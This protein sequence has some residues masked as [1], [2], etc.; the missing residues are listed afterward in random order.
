VTE[1]LY[2]LWLAMPAGARPPDHY[3]LLGVATFCD[4][5]PAIEAATRKQLR[6]LDKYA[7]HPD[8]AK[9]AACAAMMNEVARARVCLTHAQRK[10]A[11][12]ESLGRVHA[13]PQ[14][15]SPAAGDGGNLPVLE[16]ALPPQV[17]PATPAGA[18]VR[19]E[20]RQEVR[21]HLHQWILNGH[22][23]RLLLATAES[24]GLAERTAR[25]IIRRVDAEAD[26]AAQ[27]ASRRWSY[28]L[29][30]GAAA[31]L[32]IVLAVIFPPAWLGSLGDLF[33][34][35]SQ[36]PQAGAGG[37]GERKASDNAP[38]AAAMQTRL[39][40]ALARRAYAEVPAMVAQLR[41]VGGAVEAEDLVA[42]HAAK[43]RSD[44]TGLLTAGQ[45]SDAAKTSRD[46]ALLSPGD[47]GAAGQIGKKTAALVLA[48]LS[49]HDAS[50]ARRDVEAAL[51]LS[52]TDGGALSAAR[53]IARK[54]AGPAAAG[55]A[56]REVAT[57][58]PAGEHPSSGPTA[59]AK[60]PTSSPGEPGTQAAVQNRWLLEA[61]R[62][63]ASWPADPAAMS[64]AQRAEVR[65]AWADVLRALS[66]QPAD[67]GALEL[68]AKITKYLT[69]SGGPHPPEMALAL[70]R[71]VSMRL[72]QIPPGR[73][74]LGSGDDEKGRRANEGPRR[75]VTITRPFFLG[76]FE[77]TQEQYEQ[78]MGKNPSRFKGPQNPVDSVGWDD[79]VEFCK[80]LSTMTGKTVSLPTEA[81][82]E[83]ACRAGGKGRFGFGDNDA[84]LGDYA[85][86]MANSDRKTHPVGGKKPNAFGLYDMHGNVWEWCS[87]RYEDSYVLAAQPGASVKKMDPPAPAPGSASDTPRVLRGGSWVCDAGLCRS[88]CREKC[89]PA[90]GVFDYGFRV[91]VG[92][93][94]VNFGA[95]GMLADLP[96]VVRPRNVRGT[97]VK[98][99]GTNLIVRST[100]RPDVDPTDTTVTTNDKTIVTLDGKPAKLVDL[101]EGM[102]VTVIPDLTGQSAFAA[103]I[104]AR[105]PRAP[106]PE[107]GPA[108]RG[109]E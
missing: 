85:W 74:A 100:T 25:R 32:L 71:G 6:Q 60:S 86:H 23:M 66:A 48:A 65:T 77:V 34:S 41:A 49:T 94:G 84:D 68:R 24:M 106:R 51:T 103:R 59:L 26:E 58:S 14:A 87:D 64:P 20:F 88:A 95:T 46:L 47:L 4:D 93:A 79:A 72:V 37:G 105:A 83:Y 8:R 102:T 13:A 108:G 1:D 16:V 27:Q 28:I 69:Q 61:G 104:M 52:P 101:K 5:L 96:K 40:Q 45:W 12:D 53:T 98:V 70:G 56:T 90:V 44:L 9:R 97:I 91:A 73:F 38:S 19:E 36:A 3:A 54:F 107:R 42:A 17:S 62:L 57:T 10:R 7:I 30:G 80:T 21:R 29:V 89:A 67:P 2:S 15:P 63:L 99:D 75:E 109:P 22:E 55:P 92:V 82:W 50:A 43:L 76:V 78:V 11:Y 18:D 33:H 81:Q 35:A 39:R 31:A